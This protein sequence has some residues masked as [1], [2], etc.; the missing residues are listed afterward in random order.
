M[1]DFG[2]LNW[3]WI[4]PVLG[5]LVFVHELGHFV[6]ARLNGIRVDEFGLGFPPRLFGIKRGGVL[7][8]INALPIGGFVRIYGENG[9]NVDEP[10]AFGAKKP[11]Q[12]A[13]VLCAGSGMNILL[14][15][16]IFAA[17]AMVGIPSPQGAQITDVAADSPASTAGLRPADKIRTIDGTPIASPDDVARAVSPVVG[18]E[19]SIVVD[20]NG[21]QQTLR[22]TPRANPPAGQGAIGIQISEERVVEERYG[23]VEALGIGAKRTVET[24]GLMITGLGDL[25]TGRASTGDLAGPVGIAQLTS[26]IADQGRFKLLLGWTALL[27]LNLFLVNMLPLPALDGGR[28]VFVLLEAIRRKKVAPQREAFVH[29]VGMMLLLTFLVVI[30]FFDV[31]RIVQGGSILP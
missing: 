29:A 9:E 28:L 26:E 18:R 2:F 13:L 8:S 10:G 31:Q 12:R 6:T 14:A 1:L 7:Y 3:L 4:I 5:L 20:R 23:P 17:L 25:I 11:W 15:F 30:S 16:L 24:I 22:V 19:V 21:Q 27:S